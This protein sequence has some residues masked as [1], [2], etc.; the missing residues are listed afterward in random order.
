MTEASSLT[1][2]EETPANG[3][4]KIG[5]ITAEFGNPVINCDWLVSAE[6]SNAAEQDGLSTTWLG[7]LRDPSGRDVTVDPENRNIAAAIKSS[8]EINAN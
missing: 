7:A 6:N 8:L 5:P 1:A 4:L 2:S 3:K